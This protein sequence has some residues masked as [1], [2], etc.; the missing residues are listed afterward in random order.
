MICY[1]ISIITTT[2]GCSLV[3]EGAADSKS[4]TELLWLRKD[5]NLDLLGLDHFSNNGESPMGGILRIHVPTHLEA[6]T[7]RRHS[8]MLKGIYQHGQTGMVF[9]FGSVM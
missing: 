5:L 7:F 8:Q 4:P 6:S 1:I 2:V 3:C 9:A